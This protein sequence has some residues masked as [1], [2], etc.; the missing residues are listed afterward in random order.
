MSYVKKGATLKI[1]LTEKQLN[2]RQYWAIFY[3]NFDWSSVI[4]S[5][6]TKIC[7]DSNKKQKIWMHVD[8]NIIKCKYR[9]P[10]KINVWGAIIKDKGLI[11]KIFDGIENIVSLF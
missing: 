9:Y 7:N 5:D 10:L 3:N 2:D 11:F 8:E 6:E 4:W 1:P